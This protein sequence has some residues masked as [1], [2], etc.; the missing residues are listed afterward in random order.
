MKR[1][2]CL[3]V[4]ICLFLVF[5]LCGCALE[6]NENPKP[7]DL[8]KTYSLGTGSI[9]YPDSWTVESSDSNNAEIRG[10]GGQIIL[11]RLSGITSMYGETV[12]SDNYFDAAHEF[13]DGLD[14]SNIEV[15]DLSAGKLGGC[16]YSISAPIKINVD[17]NE[18]VGTIALCG[19]NDELF[20]ALVSTLSNYSESD[21]LTVEEIISSIE[22]LDKSTEENNSEN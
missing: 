15:G 5:F 8:N 1:V 17:N 21:E 11:T 3:T 13:I 7:L 18:A 14:N 4:S 19:A 22:M 2:S 6:S 12:E 10:E 9:K 20:V 16:N